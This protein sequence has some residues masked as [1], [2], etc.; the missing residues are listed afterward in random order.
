MKKKEFYK[1]R[2]KEGAYRKMT[3]ILKYFDTGQAI[4]D[5]SICCIT[6]VLTANEHIIKDFTETNFQTLY[7]IKIYG[8][9][10]EQEAFILPELLEELP[11]TD[12]IIID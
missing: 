4:K 3:S 5:N 2:I 9:K 8:A 1:H 12:W 7:Q 10:T 11:T 6:D